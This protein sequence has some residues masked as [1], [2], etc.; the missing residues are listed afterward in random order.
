M[1]IEWFILPFA[2]FVVSEKVNRYYLVKN[3]A[4]APLL[5]FMNIT[6][7]KATTITCCEY[8]Y[9]NLSIHYRVGGI[10]KYEYHLDRGPLEKN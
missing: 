7:P 4:T 8:Y 9:K 10:R 3:R 6:L 5:Y 2:L 1:S